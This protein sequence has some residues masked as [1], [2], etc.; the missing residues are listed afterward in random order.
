MD[1]EGLTRLKTELFERL[2]NRGG[3][4]VGPMTLERG[5]RESEYPEEFPPASKR[6]VSARWSGREGFSLLHQGE[7]L[8]LLLPTRGLVPIPVPQSQGK[9]LAVFWRGLC[10][11]GDFGEV[12]GLCAPV[13][14]KEMTFLLNVTLN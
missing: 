9:P 7:V 10:V 12:M 6:A 11:K 1:G 8:E 2:A 4:S 13:K 3:R 5:G 14:W